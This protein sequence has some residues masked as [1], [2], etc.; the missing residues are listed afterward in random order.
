M[1][2]QATSALTFSSLILA[3]AS[4]A[5]VAYHG[6]DGTEAPQVP[7]N[8][9]DLFDCKQIVNDAIRMFLA[10]APETGW[11]W[12]RPIAS[13]DVWPTV[14]ASASR[15]VSGGAHDTEND[16]TTLTANVSVFYET[17]ELKSIVIAGVGT[18]T[19][20]EYV[21]ATSMKV[22]G[23]ASA[24]SSA[25]FSIAADGNYAMPRNFTGTQ[26]GAITF[27]P[28]TNRSV[29]IEWSSDAV[30]RQQRENVLVETGTP[31]LAVLTP[32]AADLRRYI[33]RVWPTPERAYVLQF[34]YDLHFDSLTA[35]TEHPPTPIAHDETIRAAC[36]AVLERDKFDGGNGSAMGYYQKCLK[37]SEGIDK[38]SAPRKLGYFGSGRTAGMSRGFRNWAERPDVTYGG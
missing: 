24:A 20:E 2:E 14:D 7:T 25:Q 10:D 22:S 38:R 26:S 32:R 4:R 13:V 17:M 30:V 1:S 11:R 28:E 3:I 29:P 31:R 27:G 9:V 12:T 8:A 21:S 37:N 5:G 36:L 23:N 19:I 33:F 16:Q 15:T 35:L 6:A 34:P 18:F